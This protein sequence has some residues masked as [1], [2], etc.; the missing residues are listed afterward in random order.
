MLIG[1]KYAANISNAKEHKREKTYPQI[2][3][4][5]DKSL[6]MTYFCHIKRHKCLS[7]FVTYVLKTNTTPYE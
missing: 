5:L 4:S 3:S 7:P 1:G 2:Q 6:F